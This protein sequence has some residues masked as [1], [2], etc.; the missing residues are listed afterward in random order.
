M[1]KVFWIRYKV[2][3]VPFTTSN[4]TITYAAK[5]SEI[6]YSTG[7]Y[8]TGTVPNN[9]IMYRYTVP[10]DYYLRGFQFSGGTILAMPARWAP[11][12][13]MWAM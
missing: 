11:L 3:T 12:D 9:L 10:S 8:A 13:S 5:E 7:T 1:C 2:P 4:A 6:G